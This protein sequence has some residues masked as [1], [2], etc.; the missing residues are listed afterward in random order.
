VTYSTLLDE[1]ADGMTRHAAREAINAELLRPLDGS[2]EEIDPEAWSSSPEA[3]AAGDDS[4][5]SDSTF[6]VV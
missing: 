5:W 3:I 6:G 1:R 4:F 2:V